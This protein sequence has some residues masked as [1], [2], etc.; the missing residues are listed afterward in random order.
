MRAEFSTFTVISDDKLILS[1]NYSCLNP[2]HELPASFIVQTAKIDAPPHFENYLGAK[3][4]LESVA[5]A[6]QKIYSLSES[7]RKSSSSEQRR[8]G[9]NSLIDYL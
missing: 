9:T 2:F 1:S 3:E 7:S 8:M 4:Q 5:K 6:K